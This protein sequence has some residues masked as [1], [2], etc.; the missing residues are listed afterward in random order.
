MLE[1]NMYVF[2]PEGKCHTY[3]GWSKIH[4][5]PDDYNKERYK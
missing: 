2:S 4:C 5:A 1:T 3:T